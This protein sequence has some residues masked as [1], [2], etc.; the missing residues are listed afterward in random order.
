MSHARCMPHAG[1]CCAA[2]CV[3]LDVAQPGAKTV[4][5]EYGQGQELGTS[6]IIYFSTGMLE[7]GK[8]IVA[9][10]CS[11]T[12]DQSNCMYT[13]QVIRYSSKAKTVVPVKQASACPST[14]LST[15]STADSEAFDSGLNH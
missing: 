1:H 10:G 11:I 2:C 9:R 6:T 8:S 5:Q 4:S 3:D 15:H 7:P 13:G 12:Y 14:W